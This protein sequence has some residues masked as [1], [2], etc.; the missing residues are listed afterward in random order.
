MTGVHQ[1]DGRSGRPVEAFRLPLASHWCAWC[2]MTA[3]HFCE[4]GCGFTGKQL[5]DYNAC[6]IVILGDVT[7]SGSHASLLRDFVSRMPAQRLTAGIARCSAAGQ[8][9]AFAHE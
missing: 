4:S 9:H 6:V 5:I 3:F 1:Q 2:F 7:A 8:R